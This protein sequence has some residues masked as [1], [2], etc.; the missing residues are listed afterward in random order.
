MSDEKLDII[1][2]KLVSIIDSM[3]NVIVSLGGSVNEFDVV[4][5]ER[6]FLNGEIQHLRNL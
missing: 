1:E 4:E 3:K 6:H 5:A 2:R